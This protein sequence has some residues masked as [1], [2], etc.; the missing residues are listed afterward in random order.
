MDTY[1]LKAMN[2]LK[3]RSDF[4]SHKFN[5]GYYDKGQL[6]SSIKSG[7]HRSEVS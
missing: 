6:K 1:K 3:N 5:A 7:E 2:R 4:E